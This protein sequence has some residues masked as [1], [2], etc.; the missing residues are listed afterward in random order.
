M[1]KILC[2]L[3]NCQYNG[4]LKTPETYNHKLNYIAIGEISTFHGQ[5]RKNEIII[6][7]EEK[8][9]KGNY[10]IKHKIAKCLSFNNKR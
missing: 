2:N 10:L 3:T 4:P 8:E 1:T 7:F 6:E 5:C 9:I